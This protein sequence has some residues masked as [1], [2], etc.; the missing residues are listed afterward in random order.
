MNDDD[1]AALRW[2]LYGQG[3]K[4]KGII[5]D[6][7]EGLQ[8]GYET[9]IAPGRAAMIRV[10]SGPDPLN[11]VIHSALVKAGVPSDMD[12][13]SIA[14][15]LEPISVS[16]LW[17]RAKAKRRCRG[18]PRKD[19]DNAGGVFEM[20]LTVTRRKGP[21][22]PEKDIDGV[23]EEMIATKSTDD[24]RNQKSLPVQ[25]RISRA[26]FYRRLKKGRAARAGRSLRT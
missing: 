24:G 7:P 23:V 2:A 6:T 4:R 1:L 11:A 16:K 10:L 18:R 12:Q 22:R 15:A 8:V 25:L 21:G 13:R 19:I 9:A 20:R 5:Y 26:T 3:N 14:L 17:I